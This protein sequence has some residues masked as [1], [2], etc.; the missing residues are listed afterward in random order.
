MIISVNLHIILLNVVYTFV[1]IFAL[2]IINLVYNYL[3]SVYYDRLTFILGVI[4]VLLII[5]YE[6]FITFRQLEVVVRKKGGVLNGR[7][8]TKSTKK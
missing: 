1:S 5:V 2:K 6:L 7:R 8:T 3:H 4:F